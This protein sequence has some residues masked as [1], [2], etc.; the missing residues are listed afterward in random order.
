ACGHARLLERDRNR[1]TVA[2]RAVA[3]DH[4]M[5]MRSARASAGA[6]EAQDRALPDLL[7]L[8][9]RHL[10]EMPV[11]RHGTVA[12]IDIHVVGAVDAVVAALPERGAAEGLRPAV[13]TALARAHHAGG[14][15]DPAHALAPAPPPPTPPTIHPP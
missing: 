7:A 10:I 2:G 5:Q 8:L 4:E 3:H 6:R 13:V 1:L 9:R 12:V 14:H 15:A 11:G